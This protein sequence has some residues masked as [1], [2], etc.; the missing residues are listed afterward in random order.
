[1]GKVRNR[2]ARQENVSIPSSSGHQ[3]TARPGHGAKLPAPLFQSLLHQG[4]S[5]LGA[6]G[7][8]PSRPRPRVSIPSSSGHQ[9][10]AQSNGSLA[11]R[12]NDGFNPFF[13]RASVYWMTRPENGGKD[14]HE[15]QS[16]LHQGISLLVCGQLGFGRI[17]MGWF[18][19]LLHQGI[20]L[21]PCSRALKKR[22]LCPVSIPSSSGH[23]FTVLGRRALQHGIFRV[24]IPSSSGHQFTVPPQPN[25]RQR[26]CLFGFNPFFI[27]ASVYCWDC[28]T[29]RRQTASAFQSLLHQGIS[30]LGS[31]GGGSMMGGSPSFQSLLH[32]GISLLPGRRLQRQ[33]QDRQGRFNPFFIRA[34]VYCRSAASRSATQGGRVSI[35]SSSG[36]QFTEGRLSLEGRGV[37][38]VSIPSSSGHQFTGTQGA[39]QKSVAKFGFQSLLHQGISLLGNSGEIPTNCLE[40]VSI[41]SSSGHQ[42]TVLPYPRVGTSLTWNVSIPSSSGHQFT[43]GAK[44][45]PPH[46]TIYSFNPF[47]I[48]ASVYWL[49][50]VEL[51]D[52]R[53]RGDSF[54]P[55]FIRASVYCVRGLPPVHGPRSLVSIPSSSGHQFTV[56]VRRIIAVHPQR[57]NPFFIRASVYWLNRLE[58]AETSIAAVSIPSSSGHQFT[59]FTGQFAQLAMRLFQSLL[60]QG[61]SLLAFE[62]H[63]PR[64]GVVEVS[65]PS[66]S[67]HQFTEKLHQKRL[68]RFAVRVSIPSSSGHQFTD[69]IY[70]ENGGTDLARFNPFF[71]RASVYCAAGVYFAQNPYPNVSIPSSSGHQFT[72]YSV[73]HFASVNQRSFNPFFIR[74][75]VY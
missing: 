73:P 13:I 9:F 49:D 46:Q 50:K 33:R 68:R 41:P 21:L 54:N 52:A 60:H 51:A 6:S 75:S 47:F 65:I 32:Q 70:A 23:Q 38:H 19:S 64:L 15:F 44:I 59:V 34:S 45:T 39:W 11:N 5:L 22:L 30:L 67:G 25:L 4:I 72:V 10:T 16:L 26:D 20:S 55:F 35:P 2:I 24:S 27:R 36:H 53:E 42:F 14:K 58:I 28:K 61:I 18:Q 74:A 40:G 8:S 57:F 71:I 69:Y 3:F 29:I 48:R 7:R 37:V 63:G 43:E 12:S 66:S 17:R 31:G 62:Q 1:M 56:P